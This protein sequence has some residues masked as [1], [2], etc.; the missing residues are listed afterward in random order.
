MKQ[1]LSFFVF[2]TAL[3]KAALAFELELPLDCSIGKTCWVQQYA[4]HDPSANAVD[5]ACGSASYDGHDGTD[6][7]VRDT[8]VVMAVRASA[9]GTV[10]ALR[11]GVDDRLML[12][13]HP[14]INGMACGNG[15]IIAHGDGYETQYCHL[16]KGSLAVKTGDTVAA[17]T[18]LGD[19][20][21]SGAAG[22]P[23]VHIT[24]RK[25]G[26]VIDPFSATALDD[27]KASDTSLWS[28]KA[29]AQ[30]VYENGSVIRMG[31]QDGPVALAALELGNVSD[32]APE[33]DWP[34]LVAYAWA[35][36]LRQGDVVKLDVTGPDGFAAESAATL[37][38][39]KAQYFLFAG[40]KLKTARWPAGQYE[41][42][43]SVMRG[44]ATV[45][46]RDMTATVK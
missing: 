8:S 10:R 33:A 7:R 29:Q 26:A 19:V 1:L 45:L 32:G 3:T 17:G 24:V 27:C 37:D 44:E 42:I 9:A 35:I 5:F 25:H 30:L 41:A 20:G 46:H 31:W 43:V 12:P 14:A 36:N 21:Y 6:I 2:L 28:A 34:A 23:H 11:D 40:K 39:N 13:D 4:D 22:F 18:R 16:R 38:H 15:V